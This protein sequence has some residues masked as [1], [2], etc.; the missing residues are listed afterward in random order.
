MI[1]GREADLRAVERL[2]E[3]GARVVTLHGPSGIGK[4]ALAKA[5]VARLEDV[6]FCDVT[7]ARDL[8]EVC[9]V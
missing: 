2:F 9:M 1:V 6:V 3:E 5:V 7:A 8:A 4:T